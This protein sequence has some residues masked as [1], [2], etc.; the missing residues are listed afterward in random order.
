MALLDRSMYLRFSTDDQEMLTAV[1]M[2]TSAEDRA[3]ALVEGL[4][5]LQE[6]EV[7][8]D[9]TRQ[10]TEEVAAALESATSLERTLLKGVITAQSSGLLVP[11]RFQLLVKNL[12]SFRVMAERV[13]FSGIQDALMFD[14][15]KDGQS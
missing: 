15:A 10:A 7:T 8:P 3:R 12:N 9:E 11:L 4:A 14:L 6:R 5:K 1:I 13:G 2:A